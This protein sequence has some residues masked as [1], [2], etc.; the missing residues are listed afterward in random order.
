MT[1]KLWLAMI[2][3]IQQKTGIDEIPFS[4]VERLIKTTKANV[5]KFLMSFS[6]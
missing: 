1:A 4:L 3:D 2:N 5:N 6:H